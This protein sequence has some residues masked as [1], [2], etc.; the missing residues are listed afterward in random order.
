MAA[1]WLAHV[2]VS[3]A[4]ALFKASHRALKIWACAA[5]VADDGCVGSVGGRS[6][7]GERE[8]S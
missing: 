5:D 7:A 4:L 1:L 6:V 8:A 2:A 3:A